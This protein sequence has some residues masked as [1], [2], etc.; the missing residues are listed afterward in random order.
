MRAQSARMRRGDAMSIRKVL[1]AAVVTAA[2]FGAS[3][4]AA[5]NVA[6]YFPGFIVRTVQRAVSPPTPLPA[7]ETADVSTVWKAAFYATLTEEARIVEKQV[8]R[9]GG[10]EKVVFSRERQDVIIGVAPDKDGEVTF[11]P[12]SAIKF[13]GSLGG[14]MVRHDVKSSAT[15]VGDPGNPDADYDLLFSQLERGYNLGPRPKVAEFA[16]F[17]IRHEVGGHCVERWAK[18]VGLQAVH[19]AGDNWHSEMIADSYATFRYAADGGDGSMIGWLAAVRTVAATGYSGPAD[20]DHWTSEAIVRA[21][22]EA[23]ALRE[24]GVEI[25][26][27]LAMTRA[28]EIADGVDARYGFGTRTFTAAVTDALTRYVGKRVTFYASAN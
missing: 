5:F 20:V 28:I 22:N 2:A 27:A 4:A 23:K 17:V 19:G 3:P 9:S 18:M 6:D 24:S 11:E 8:R 12:H 21:W 16:A 25:T 14:D 15:C 10:H 26:P 13:G 7:A 1:M